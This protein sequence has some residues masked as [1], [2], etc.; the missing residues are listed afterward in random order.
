LW[1]GL[2]EPDI[3]QGYMPAADLNI[4]SLCKKILLGLS[5]NIR[6]RNVDIAG[7][8]ENY[9]LLYFCVFR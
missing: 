4:P 2:A 8:C 3:A 9:F 6:D 1:L 5:G 7:I